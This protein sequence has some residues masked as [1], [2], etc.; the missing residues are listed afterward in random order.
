MCQRHALVSF[1]QGSFRDPAKAFYGIG[2][3]LQKR[4]GGKV[5]F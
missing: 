4:K 2:I 3:L 1:F 5:D